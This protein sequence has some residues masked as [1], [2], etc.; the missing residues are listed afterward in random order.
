ML[1]KTFTTKELSSSRIWQV[2]STLQLL[3][4]TIWKT[5][6]GR[7]IARKVHRV[8][9]HLGSVVAPR[10][11]QRGS[12]QETSWRECTSQVSLAMRLS[13]QM[14]SLSR[15]RWWLRSWGMS[16]SS[17]SS[18]HSTSARPSRPTDWESCMAPALL[19]WMSTIRAWWI[20][21][22]RTERFC[23]LRNNSVVWSSWLRI[24]NCLSQKLL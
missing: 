1:W 3:P 14:T 7:K 8:E 23:W 22:K 2:V 4:L 5:S 15:T 6:L 20:L 24:L 11:L 18:S 12:L 13:S 10:I 21:S 16:T 17:Q 9:V 19:P